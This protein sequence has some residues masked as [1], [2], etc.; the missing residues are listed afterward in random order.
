MH[1]NR[2]ENHDMP[3]TKSKGRGYLPVP[4]YTTHKN[5]PSL[6][7]KAL[8]IKPRHLL[9]YRP[10]EKKNQIAQQKDFSSV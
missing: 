7:K 2:P 3:S 6:S 4:T 8:L 1:H 9:V 5:A 10:K